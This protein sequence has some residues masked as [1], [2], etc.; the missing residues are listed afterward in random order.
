MLIDDIAT[1]LVA[2]GVGT[3]G[4]DIFKG[5]QPPEP[6]ECLVIIP[7]GGLAPD[8]DLVGIK[9]P[10]IQILTRAA[11][12]SAAMALAEAA[13]D[14]LH[15]LANTTLGSTYVMYCKA[16]QEPTSIGQDDN[17]NFEISCNYL[18]KVR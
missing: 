18:L 8:P 11:T 12:I 17:S 10:T 16:L 1:Y 14:A 7:T 15:G 2:E 9:D 13:Y 6:T 5:F 3:I 4:T